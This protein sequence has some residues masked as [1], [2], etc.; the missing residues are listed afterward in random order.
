MGSVNILDKLQQF[1]TDVVRVMPFRQAPRG[2]AATDAIDDE[3]TE[4]EE[5]QF[6]QMVS[7]LG[8]L[9]P[10][11]RPSPEFRARLKEALLA[12]HRRRLANEGMLPARQEGG[13]SWRWSLAATVPLLIGVLATILWRRSHRSNEQLISPVGGR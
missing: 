3:L 4:E 7:F 10:F 2:E 9:F 5:E 6:A 11:A 1:R 13:I 8:R 12:E